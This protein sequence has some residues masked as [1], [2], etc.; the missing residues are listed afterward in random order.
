M[1]KSSKL[2]SPSSREAP[3]PKLQED[4]PMWTSKR[5]RTAALQDLAER[6]ACVPSRQ[7]L[8]VRPSSSAF[9][10]GAIQAMD[11]DSAYVGCY[12]F[13]ILN[14]GFLW[15]LELGIWSFWGIWNLVFSA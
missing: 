1:I 2:Q 6:V 14:L 15:S 13:G 11:Y 9:R 10:A 4:R 3:K 8:G 5:Q 12:T 7:R